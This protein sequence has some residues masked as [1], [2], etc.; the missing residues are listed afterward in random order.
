[1]TIY[2]GFG[3]NSNK[4]RTMKPFFADF[5]F[6]LYKMGACCVDLRIE[7]I[8]QMLSFQFMMEYFLKHCTKQSLAIEV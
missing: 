5:T 1:M 4:F 6:G 7:G 2:G 8:S 3:G